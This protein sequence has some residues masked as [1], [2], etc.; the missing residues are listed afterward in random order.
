VIDVGCGTGRWMTEAFARGADIAGI[1]FSWGML[2]VAARK[3]ALSGRLIL[4]H[5]GHLPIQTGSM[6]LALCSMAMSYFPSLP[7]AFSEMARIVRCG[8]RVVLSDLHPDAVA[9]GWKRSFRAEGS[10]YEIEHQTFS[11]RQVDE[12]ARRV[13]L[14]PAWQIEPCF[15]KPERR[16]F[17]RAGKDALFAQLSRQPALHIACWTKL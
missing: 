13:G 12:A 9:A 8:A 4:G 2:A 10:S 17:E 14:E 3:P 7:D 1:D 16:I 11:I 15:G 6:D 5:S